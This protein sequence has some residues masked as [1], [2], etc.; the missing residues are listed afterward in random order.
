MFKVTGPSI[1][2]CVVCLFSAEGGVPPLTNKVDITPRLQFELFKMGT[3]G[4]PVSTSH[5][6]STDRIY[7]EVSATP[8][9]GGDVFAR[10]PREQ[11]FNF[12]LRDTNGVEVSKTSLGRLHTNPVDTSKSAR[13]LKVRHRPI[14]ANGGW[15]DVLFI[16]D[17]FFVITNVGFYTL[18]V[19]LRCWTQTT[20][21]QYGIVVSPPV[22][23]LVEKRFKP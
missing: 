20:N 19:Q 13:E 5:F 8:H 17:D 16:P 22:Q 4:E 10:L 12:A 21:G 15:V 7:Y 11:A 18:E 14:T 3:N 1:V 2:A 23:V 9:S 6:V